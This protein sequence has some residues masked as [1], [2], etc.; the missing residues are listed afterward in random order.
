MQDPRRLDRPHWSFSSLNQV[1]NI[2]SLQ[3]YFQRVA[4]IEPAFT[5]GQARDH[6]ISYML[7][8]HL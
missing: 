5:Y 4:R 2:C 7:T 8:V 1:L 3:Y 6:V